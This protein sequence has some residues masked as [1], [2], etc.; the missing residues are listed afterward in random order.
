MSGSYLSLDALKSRP[1][2]D[3]RGADEDA[4][5]LAV[6]EAASRLVDRYCNRHFFELSAARVFDGTGSSPL[7]LPDLIGVDPPGL[8]TDDDADGVFETAWAPAG[9]LLLPSNADPETASNP[10]SRP[11]TAVE[12]APRAQTRKIGS[13]PGA[14]ASRP[15]LTAGRRT[16]EITGRWGWWRHL[17]PA[18]ETLGA[19]VDAAATSLALSRSS[20]VE[21]GH[22]LLVGSEQLCVR[23]RDGDSLTV[24]R[25]VNGTTAAAHADAARVWIYEYPA[26][27]V[28]AT[29]LQAVRLWR[30]PRRAASAADAGGLDP[31]ARLLLSGYRKPALGV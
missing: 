30:A 23:G 2:L 13:L 9:Y 21:T 20:G 4:R 15:H 22:T 11:Y 27:V 8:R 28:E 14:R 17:R 18:A 7:R 5:L 24:A 25:G 19:S 31:E 3:I 12:V 26:P 16:V 1:A 6:L 10:L 29:L